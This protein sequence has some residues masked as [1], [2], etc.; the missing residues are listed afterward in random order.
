MEYSKATI[1]EVASLLDAF[2]E[3]AR[4]YKEFISYNWL[5]ETIRQYRDYYGV[6]VE[7]DGGQ[8]TEAEER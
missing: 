7:E 2:A 1:K 6:G 8:T 5:I 3:S 4:D